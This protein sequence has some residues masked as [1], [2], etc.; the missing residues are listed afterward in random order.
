MLTKLSLKIW[1]DSAAILQYR[2]NSLW[3]FANYVLATESAM[4]QICKFGNFETT[5]L[6]NLSELL[7]FWNFNF[8]RGTRVKIW[9]FE[10][11]PRANL[12]KLAQ[13]LCGFAN[14]TQ[15]YCNFAIL[16]CIYTVHNVPSQTESTLMNREETESSPAH[17]FHD[18]YCTLRRSAIRWDTDSPAWLHAN[19]STLDLIHG[20]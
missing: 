14:L 15:L 9:K 18:R 17:S 20:S 19:R 5:L 10:Y 13:L 3:K 12:K 7:Q 11:N 1:L 16:E 8:S 6:E 4:L 2:Q